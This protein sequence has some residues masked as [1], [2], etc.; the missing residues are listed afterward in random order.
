VVQ[1]RS[2]RLFQIR[3]FLLTLLI[4]VSLLDD[5]PPIPTC[6]NTPPRILAFFE[7]IILAFSRRD[8]S[9]HTGYF[10]C[11]Y[12]FSSLNTV[13]LFLKIQ[14][15]QKSSYPTDWLRWSRYSI[16]QTTTPP[17]AQAQCILCPD[18]QFLIAKGTREEVSLLH[19]QQWRA[20]R[21]VTLPARSK[22]LIISYPFG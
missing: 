20:L 13:F 18:F 6:E 3:R 1:N 9:V 19:N 15:M 21:V 5:L 17:I 12:S 11:R 22:F 16:Y 4:C 8:D 7:T 14:R 10:L 2:V